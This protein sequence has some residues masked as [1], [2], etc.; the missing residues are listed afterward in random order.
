MSKEMVF[1]GD[2]QLEKLQRRSVKKSGFVFKP[3]LSRFLLRNFS[4][5]SPPLTII[6][7]PITVC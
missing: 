3:G 7:L 1:V 2:L 6:S 4:Y 5:C